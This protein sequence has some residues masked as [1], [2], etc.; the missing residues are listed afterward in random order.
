MQEES[1]GD[2]GAKKGGPQ[3]HGGEDQTELARLLLP[4]QHEAI[5]NLY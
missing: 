3:E 2:L 4:Q 1:P 5:D